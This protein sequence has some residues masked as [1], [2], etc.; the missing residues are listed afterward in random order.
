MV[1][2]QGIRIVTSTTIDFASARSAIT[3][4]RASLGVPLVR[5]FL[6]RK[7]FT[8]EEEE[9]THA[10]G[11]GTGGTGVPGVNAQVEFQPRRYE[12]R[13]IATV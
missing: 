4:G 7:P 6:S 13:L 9:K 12:T 3:R 10:F 2:G 1:F 8:T 11:C 5:S